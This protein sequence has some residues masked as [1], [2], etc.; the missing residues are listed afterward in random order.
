MLMMMVVGLVAVLL[1]VRIG[2][3]T[4]YSVRAEAATAG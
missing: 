3:V 2:P 4:N 1:A